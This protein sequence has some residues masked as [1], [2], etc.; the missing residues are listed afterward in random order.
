MT[1]DYCS[2]PQ[3]SVHH[4]P[5]V[6]GSTTASIC[7][8]IF[9]SKISFSFGHAQGMQKFL[10]QGL[11]LCHSSNPSHSSDNAGS[12]VTR[13]PANSK[14]FFFKKIRFIRDLHSLKKFFF[15]F[16]ATPVAYES[17]QARGWIRTAAASLHHSHSNAG[18]LTHWARTG[19]E[20]ASSWILVGFLTHWTTLG[21]PGTSR[22]SYWS[23]RKPMRTKLKLSQMFLIFIKYRCTREEERNQEC[24]SCLGAGVLGHSWMRKLKSVI[25][26][27]CT[28]LA[29]TQSSSTDKNQA[30]VFMLLIEKRVENLIISSREASKIG[31]KM[32]RSWKRIP[33]WHQEHG[34]TGCS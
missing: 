25:N 4:A 23:L 28:A 27:S 20:P 22:I 3:Q 2:L 33:A 8:L 32:Q 14:N 26:S 18:S 16:M 15:L 10:G 13:P 29:W 11:N 34:P 9:N 7:A 5:T 1:T 12:L 6:L 19:M 17:S 24:R 31:I 21:T 30:L